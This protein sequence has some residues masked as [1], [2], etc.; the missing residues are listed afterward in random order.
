MKR[1]ICVITGTRA[2]YGLLYWLMKEIQSEEKLELQIIATGMHLSPEFG[3]TFRQIESDG[4]IINEKIETLLSSDTPIGIVKSIGL[5]VIGFADAFSR[6]EPDIIVVLG[7]RY[8]I[9]A[10]AQAAMIM[11]IPIAHLHGG[12][13]TE[14]AFDEGIRHAITKMANL[15]FVANDVYCKR[16]IQ[17]GEAPERVYN[18][19]AIGLDNINKLPLLSLNELMDALDFD[20]G[21][22][23]FLVTYHPATL[24]N[25]KP[26]QCMLSLLGALDKFPNA[27]IIFT[28]A[29]ADTYGRIINKMIEDYVAR[30]SHRS[31]VF[32]SLGQLRYLSALKHVDAVIGNS[33]SGL[34]EAPA[35]RT[36]TINIGNRQKGRLR[37][38]TVIDCAENETDIINAIKTALSSRFR[39]GLS[40]VVSPYGE[41]NSSQRIVSKLKEID[42]NNLLIKKFYDI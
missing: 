32:T 22:L 16:V 6:L 15:H 19:G 26:E 24:S 3:E 4:F 25:M 10:G 9:L 2:E 23:S 42:L 38:S 35:L 28:K 7:D 11:K 12:E 27:K 40:K 5:G 33:S 14:G 21:E 8:E 30:Q 34:I 18:Y 20:L 39:D 37:A 31:T 29:N 1:R 13:T 41:G 36:P 17:L